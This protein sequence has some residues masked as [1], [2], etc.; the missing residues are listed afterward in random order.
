MANQVASESF[1]SVV[2]FY[3]GVY[4]DPGSCYAHSVQ[5]VFY[6]G[7]LC[8][9]PIFRTL[10]KLSEQFIKNAIRILV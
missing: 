8:I 3:F 4:L 9:G 10:I 6:Q 2:L 1:F 7:F 5:H